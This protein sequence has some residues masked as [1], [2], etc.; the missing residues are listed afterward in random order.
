MKTQE[1]RLNCLIEKF[2]EESLEYK[3]FPTPTDIEEKKVLLRS[4][5]NIL[6]KKKKLYV[7]LSLNLKKQYFRFNLMIEKYF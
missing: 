5:M 2:K 4:L 1:E 7:S 6:I 3:D